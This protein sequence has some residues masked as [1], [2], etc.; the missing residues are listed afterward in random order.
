[1]SR[2][3]AAIFLA[4]LAGT[5]GCHQKLEGAGGHCGGPDAGAAAAAPAS[6]GAGCPA[7]WAETEITAAGYS[8]TCTTTG[9]ICTYP[10]GE[11]ECALDGTTL[12]WWTVGATPGCGETAPTIGTRCGSPGLNCQ[13]ISGPPEGA[14]TT[15]YCCDGTQCA[16]TLQGSNGCPNGNTCGAISTSDYDQSCSVDTD[17]VMELEGDFCSTQC[18]CTKGVISVKAQTQYETDLVSRISTSAFECPCPSGPRAVCTQGRCATAP[19]LTF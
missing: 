4:A 9:L 18:V 14:F 13:Y 2:G 7:T 5:S 10:E 3:G 12:R 6:N 19:L 11:A 17:C 1:M 16:W 15:S 8:A